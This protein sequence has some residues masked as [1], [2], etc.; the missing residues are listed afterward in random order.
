MPCVALNRHVYRSKDSVNWVV[1]R[2]FSI[3]RWNLRVT[4]PSSMTS[5]QWVCQQQMITIAEQMLHFGDLDPNAYSHYPGLSHMNP[6]AFACLQHHTEVVDML[7]RS[8]KVLVDSCDM[9]GKTPLLNSCMQGSV[10]MIRRLL[11]AGACCNTRDNKF[12]TPLMHATRLNVK[13]GVRLLLEHGAIA[14]LKNDEGQ[15]ALEIAQQYAFPPPEVVN[16][17]Q[18]ADAGTESREKHL[19]PQEWPLN[20]G[21]L[22]IMAGLL[23]LTAVLL[24][25]ALK[26]IEFFA[27]ILTPSYI[28]TWPNRI[29]VFGVFCTIKMLVIAG[30][31]TCLA[32]VTLII[33]SGG[34]VEAVRAETRTFQQCGQRYDF[35]VSI[36]S[37]SSSGGSSS[38]SSS[39]GSSSIPINSR[40]A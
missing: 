28:W 29:T 3:N 11:K 25:T 33:I 5:F 24:Y 23:A 6:L 34:G 20:V 26:L 37:S 38:S 2:H 18:A 22:L 19:Q 39:G 27:K 35:N 21:Q 14:N 9:Y 17:L 36:S 32:A 1:N 10:P 13:E 16:M 8:D 4:I 12:C 7:L 31:G 40:M 15:S 30:V